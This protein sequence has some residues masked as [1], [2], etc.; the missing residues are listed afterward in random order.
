VIG[1]LFLLILANAPLRILQRQQALN[2]AP[3]AEPVA[4]SPP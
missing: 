1:A 3:Q 4:P 2:K